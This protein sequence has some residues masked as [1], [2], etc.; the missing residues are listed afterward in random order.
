VKKTYIVVFE[1]NSDDDTHVS[2]YIQPVCW[3]I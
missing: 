3:Y 1:D 2:D